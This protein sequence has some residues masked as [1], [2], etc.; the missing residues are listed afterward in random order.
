MRLDCNLEAAHRI[1]LTPPEDKTG[2]CSCS[3]CGENRRKIQYCELHEKGLEEESFSINRKEQL[4]MGALL[5]DI[6]KLVIPLSVMNKASRLGGRET[7]I[8]A[9]LQSY[10]L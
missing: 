7:E 8:K 6:G 1:Y 4:V 9:R 3:L 2:I 5:H 10:A